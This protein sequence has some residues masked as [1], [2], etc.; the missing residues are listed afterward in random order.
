M[1]RAYLNKLALR[2][3]MNCTKGRSPGGRC[4]FCDPVFP[5]AMTNASTVAGFP[6]GG[7]PAS[8]AP[9]LPA[10]RQQ[11]SG[12]VKIAIE[13]LGV[14]ATFF[15]C[16]SIRRGG[17][18][19]AVQ[20]RVPEPIMFRQSGHGTALAGRRNVHPVDPRVLYATARAVLPGGTM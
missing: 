14:D 15:S 4:R 11:V 12:A 5:R 3:S 8:R 2:I 17:L 20:A 6:V 9:L 7:G 19:A 1:F 16:L 13:C 18:T 10:S